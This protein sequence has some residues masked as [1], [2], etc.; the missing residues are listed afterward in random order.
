[1]KFMSDKN[2]NDAKNSTHKQFPTGHEIQ[3]QWLKQVHA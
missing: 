2:N 1:M 3:K